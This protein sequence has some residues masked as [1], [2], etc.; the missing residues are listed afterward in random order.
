MKAWWNLLAIVSAILGGWIVIQNHENINVLILGGIL[1][2]LIV[3]FVLFSLLGRRAVG[4]AKRKNMSFPAFTSL[5]VLAYP[6]AAFRIL[7]EPEVK[8]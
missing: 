4:Y 3:G 8:E 2:Y 7:R 1:L 6:Y 5:W